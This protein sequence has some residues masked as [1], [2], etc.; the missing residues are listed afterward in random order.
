MNLTESG[1]HF[2]ISKIPEGYPDMP[3]TDGRL[4]R[5]GIFEVSV[6]VVAK[7]AV[8]GL[9]HAMEFRAKSRASG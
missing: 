7:Y 2:S 4:Y 9:D 5:L 3:S 1:C 6:S 8:R